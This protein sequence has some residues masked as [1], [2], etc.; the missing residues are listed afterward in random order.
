MF[1]MT[2]ERN[3]A[4]AYCVGKCCKTKRSGG[5][6]TLREYSKKNTTSH[7]AR[8]TNWR[9]LLKVL[10]MLL[11][12]SNVVNGVGARSRRIDMV[13]EDDVGTSNIN[14]KGKGRNTPGGQGSPSSKSSPIN[15]GIS[16][17]KN[18]SSKGC[19]KV[20]D[21]SKATKG[22]DDLDCDK[23]VSRGREN[24]ILTIPRKNLRGSVVLGIVID[25]M[26]PCPATE[27]LAA[28][29]EVVHPLLMLE[30]RC[31]IFLASAVTGDLEKQ[32]LSLAAAT[33]CIEAVYW[34]SVISQ[35]QPKSRRLQD[36]PDLIRAIA[37]FPVEDVVESIVSGNILSLEELLEFANE[38]GIISDDDVC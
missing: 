6:Y 3:P 36:V 37:S 34:R 35:C 13:F 20:I 5:F 30:D 26:A 7:L 31:E 16:T 38:A 23:N 12:V 15:G 14:D 29:G 10:V 24:S 25:V 32:N 22:D 17:T 28:V 11:I 18:K 8:A 4:S 27:D 33:V 2:N 1:E 9:H 21:H 19:N